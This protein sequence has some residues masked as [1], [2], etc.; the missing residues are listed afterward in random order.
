MYH[1]C[2]LVECRK[3]FSGAGRL[4]LP[5]GGTVQKSEKKRFGELLWAVASFAAC[6]VSLCMQLYYQEHLV[7]IRDWSALSDTADTAAALGRNMVLFT[8]AANLL[9][10]WRIFRKDKGDRRKA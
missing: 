9:L 8:L 2:D 4:D 5:G 1:G 10:I 6:G 3:Y 7:A